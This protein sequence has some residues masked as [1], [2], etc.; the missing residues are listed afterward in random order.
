MY[1]TLPRWIAAL[2]TRLVITWG[3]PP[4]PQCIAV[5]QQFRQLGFTPWWFSAPYEIARERYLAREGQQATQDLF[6]PQ[7]VRLQQAKAQLD[8]IYQGHSVETLT[9]AGYRA[10]EQIYETIAANIA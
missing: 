9:A 6:D 7:V 5:I 10:V 4:Y 3:F 1:A 2:A 8:A